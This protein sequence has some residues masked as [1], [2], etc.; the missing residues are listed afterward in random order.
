MKFGGWG[1][2]VVEEVEWRWGEAFLGI[3]FFC[4]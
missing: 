2:G 3:I 1:G 4:R